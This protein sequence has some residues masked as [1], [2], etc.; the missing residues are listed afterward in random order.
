MIF[1]QESP[2]RSWI[3][4]LGKKKKKRKRERRR[5]PV[6]ARCMK[7]NVDRADIVFAGLRR[8]SRGISRSID[9]DFEERRRLRRD[10][11]VVRRSSAS[12][13]FG[14]VGLVRPRHDVAGATSTTGGSFFSSLPPPYQPSHR[15]FL[16]ASTG[17]R[18]APPYAPW[19]SWPRANLGRLIAHRIPVY[20]TKLIVQSS[21][22]NCMH[23]SG[24]MRS[25][26]LTLRRCGKIRK[27][28]KWMIWGALTDDQWYYRCDRRHVRV[29]NIV[30]RICNGEQKKVWQQYRK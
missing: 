6:A 5:V 21:G 26:V 20:A 8:D 2:Q 4:S 15:R 30:L 10:S 13:F 1:F 14:I 29:L 28:W 3:A 16:P 18:L 22:Q 23:I 19:N 12:S 11:S 17:F 7:F 9:R 25:F 24:S 27:S